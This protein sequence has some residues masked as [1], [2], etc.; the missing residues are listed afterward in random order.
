MNVVM[1][2]PTGIGCSIGGYAGDAT[3]A[4]KLLA[5]C[6]DRLILHPNV[7]N[8]SDINEMPDNAWYVEGSM[9]DAFLLGNIS[10]SDPRPRRNKI[11]LAVNPPMH[12]ETFNAVNAARVTIGAEIEVVEL[13]TKL[14]IEGYQGPDGAATGI[15]TGYL[16]LAN[17]VQ[18][19]DFDALAIASPVDVPK[20]RALRFL[21]QG[22]VNPWGGAEAVASKLIAQRIRKPVAHAPIESAEMEIEHFNERVD[23]RIAPEAISGTFLHCVLKGLHTA[24]RIGPPDIEN[25]V[26]EDVDFL[27]APLKCWGPPHQACQELDI[28]VIR[29]AENDTVL[30]YDGRYQ[31]DIIVNNYWEAAGVIMCERAGITRESVRR[32]LG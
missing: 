32:P 4:A 18:R 9:L 23:P 16:Q 5:K 30:E 15:V 17:Q 28:P 31:G 26:G 22:G 14:T 21:R 29:V 25:L 7:V 11:L 27:V 3:P 2:V 24:P 19:Y 8:A 10:L 1:I 13:E 6:C 20:E 12:P